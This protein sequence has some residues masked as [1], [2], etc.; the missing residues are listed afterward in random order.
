[1]AVGARMKR[2][3]EQSCTSASLPASHPM[4]R[5]GP[6]HRKENWLTDKQAQPRWLVIPFLCLEHILVTLGNLGATPYLRFL[7]HGL[8]RH[9]SPYL[10]LLLLLPDVALGLFPLLDEMAGDH[11]RQNPHH[12]RRDIPLRRPRK[13]GRDV[14]T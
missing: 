11:A 9:K 13:Q 6:S 4:T 8:G 5:I 12:M 3:V 14:E 2:L 7:F 1:M 10:H